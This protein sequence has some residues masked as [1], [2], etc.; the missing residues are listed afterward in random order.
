ML[1]FTRINAW[2]I[3]QVRHLRDAL[4]SGADGH[5]SVCIFL[6]NVNYSQFLQKDTFRIMRLRN[7]DDL[8]VIQKNV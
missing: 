3:T 2:A 8:N 5:S 6:Q 1:A 7:I 4:R